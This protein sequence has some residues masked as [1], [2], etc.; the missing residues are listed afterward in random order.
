MKWSI[1]FIHT[2]LLAF[3]LMT[4]NSN[5]FAQATQIQ[6]PKD[7]TEIYSGVVYGPIDKSDTLW[8]IS[9]QYRKNQQ[10]SVYQVM[11]AIYELNPNAFTNGN[12]NTMVN[13]SVLRLPS[14]RYIARIS[15]QAARAKA[16]QDDRSIAQAIAQSGSS[17]T[18]FTNEE[19]AI[20]NLK[21]AVPLVNKEQLDET[22]KEFQQQ[23]NSLKSQQSVIVNDLKQQL[24]QSIQATQAILDDN[25]LVLEQLAKKDQEFV[26]L[27]VEMAEDFQS[28]LD[29]QALQIQELRD[30]VR[31]AQ[32]REQQEQESSF[33]AI[34][35]EPL[36]IISLTTL[37]GLLVF[38]LVAMKLLRSPKNKDKT[39]TSEKVKNTKDTKKEEDSSDSDE[40][41]AILENDDISDDDLLDDILSDELE[42]S[43]EEVSLD[44]DDFDEIDDEMLAPDKNIKSVED[45]LSDALADLD[46]DALNLDAEDFESGIDGLD[47]DEDSD[48]LPIVD[49]DPEEVDIDSILDQEGAD[50][51]QI[52]ADAASQLIE[53]NALD[54]LSGNDE[55]PEIG[56]DQANETRPQSS[57][58]SIAMEEDEQSEIDIDDLLDQ[59]ILDSNLPKGIALDPS[60]E[61]SDAVIEQ[62]EAEIHNKNIEINTLTDSFEEDL[63][64]NNFDED[65]IETSDLAENDAKN[66]ESQKAIQPLDDITKG[67]EDE[68]ADALANPENETDLDETA[69]QELEDPLTDELLDELDV[70][71]PDDFDPDIEELLSEP[72]AQQAMLDNED[73]DSVLEGSL[74][75][76]QT[77]NIDF[78]QEENDHFDEDLLGID[79]TNEQD[80]VDIDSVLNESLEELINNQ[81]EDI[82]DLKDEDNLTQANAIDDVD[83]SSESSKS[84]ELDELLISDN[85]GTSNGLDVSDAPDAQLKSEPVDL[86]EE[87][88]EDDLLELPDLDAWLDDDES[89]NTQSTQENLQQLDAESSEYDVLREIEESDFDS[90]LE[91]MGSLS[92]EKST[93]QIDKLASDSDFDISTSDQL[94]G[95][96]NNSLDNPDLDLT[97]LFEEPADDSDGSKEFIN[98]D[99]LLKE[100]ENLTPATDEELGLDLDM[101]LDS[102]LSDDK[103]FDVDNEQASN[104]DLARVYIDMEDNEAAL[105]ALE[106]VLQKGSDEN[107]KEAQ[108]LMKQLKA[109]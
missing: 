31:Q 59:D 83:E 68:I 60:G 95:L 10:F 39:D 7:S 41:L 109:E 64:N 100:S 26:E 49:D 48:L 8:A 5:A 33:G 34:T 62:I 73:I 57:N 58:L 51:E 86:D 90:L 47:L 29:E 67:V 55:L 92:D 27:K 106:E 107:K 32:M 69:I 104:L 2:V 63:K 24:N 42:D 72:I 71:V 101:S 91:E 89:D 1:L 13:G 61:I 96:E 50:I 38:V 97:A 85:E 98:V 54:R 102:Y 25:K 77:G 80:E 88:S 87:L 9:N 99:S 18:P 78:E 43:I 46:D 28:K 22:Q 19:P 103:G 56:L 6:G 66:I 53:E 23:I 14:N 108:L 74:S 105:E 94:S 44:I 52:S 70:E 45:D 35:S 81:S 11:L 16:E 36:F 30:F 37:A 15:P 93:A 75:D 17:D 21:P 82:I 4:V 40:L 12:F 20:D 84:S 76:L 65:E 79:E 3:L